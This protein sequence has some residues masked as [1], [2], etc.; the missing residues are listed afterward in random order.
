M[1]LNVL[2]LVEN[3]IYS[4][5]S[6]N[7]ESLIIFRSDINKNDYKCIY[8]VYLKPNASLFVNLGSFNTTEALQNIREATQDEID[9]LEACEKVGKFV[10]KPIRK[11]FIKDKWYKVTSG[12]S[13][14][15][16]PWYIKYQ[17]YINKCHK[18]TD[19]IDGKLV[20]CKSNDGAFGDNG[21]Y[22]FT[23]IDLSEIQQYLPENHIDKIKTGFKKDDYIVL[24]KQYG[25]LTKINHI[26]KQR[27]DNESLCPICDCLGTKQNNYNW[28]EVYNYNSNNWRYATK[29]E[30]DHYNKIGKPYDVTTLIK[31]EY[32]KPEEL[33]QGCWY[34][35]YDQGDC[36]YLVKIKEVRA[37]TIEYYCYHNY[38]G[39][40]S[41]GLSSGPPPNKNYVYKPASSEEVLKYFPDE[42]FSDSNWIPQVGEYVIAK[43]KPLGEHVIGKLGVYKGDGVFNF[44]NIIQKDNMFKGVR[45]ALPFEIP[46]MSFEEVLIECKRRYPIGTKFHPVNHKYSNGDIS[47]TYTIMG[48]NF[49]EW[50]TCGKKTAIIE[51]STKGILWYNG[52]FAEIVEEVIN[53]VSKAKSTLNS[54][55]DF[56]YE[57]IEIGVTLKA[58][59]VSKPKKTK[60][61]LFEEITPI[62]V[63]EV[64]K[65][66]VKSKINKNK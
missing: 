32:L 37:D 12:K 22:T 18:S 2:N 47:V 51:S 36:N 46:K 66:T 35:R 10:D 62:K 57:E 48:N 19:Y 6:C 8:K 50:D 4:T 38:A 7:D 58:K 61:Q 39:N 60:L 24:L 43:G 27:E 41:H 52:V 1:G 33:V 44:D 20:F 40:F 63:E 14:L 16:N 30:I 17:G 65:L 45:K 53:P 3:K 13:R 28:G 23:L 25:Y 5:V 29:E 21:V 11:E 42:K 59:E 56:E 54:L 49:K 55:G 9:W 64:V 15:A 31:S 34:K 26:I